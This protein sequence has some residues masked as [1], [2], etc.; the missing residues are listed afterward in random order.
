METRNLPCKLTDEEL[1]FRRD[2]LAQLVSDLASEEQRKKDTAAHHSD[3]IK[4]FERDMFAVSIEIKDRAEYR[5][6]VVKREKDLENG[7]EE[8]IR[9]DTGEVVDVRALGPNE[10]QATLFEIGAEA[11]A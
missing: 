5:E 9:C 8:I 6:V 11:K 2:K 10:R 1:N 3:R 7:V 4:N